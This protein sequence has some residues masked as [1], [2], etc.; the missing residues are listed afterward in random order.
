MLVTLIGSPGHGTVVV[1]LPPA[2]LFESPPLLPHETASI[3]TTATATSMRTPRFA[4]QS[5][6][7]PLDPPRG[8][9]DAAPAPG[10]L[11]CSRHHVMGGHTAAKMSIVRFHGR[12]E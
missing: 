10:K 8:G 5:T 1:V 6:W 11:S 9:D 3:E 2:E 7:S 4:A 12:Q